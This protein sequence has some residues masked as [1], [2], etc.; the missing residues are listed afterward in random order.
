MITIPIVKEHIQ[1]KKQTIIKE[2]KEE[3]TFIKE[4]I[5][6]IKLINTN[7]IQ[8]VKC[9]ENIISAFTNLL[10]CIWIKNSKIVNI[11]KHSKSWWN[12]N[13]SRN[14]EKYRLSKS[15]KDWKQYKKTFRVTK[16]N[17]FN[18]KIQEIFNKKKGS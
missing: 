13:C 18:L 15:I 6:V 10:E 17:F 3:H 12:N 1:T 4:L 11:T 14:L 2:S 7:V 8:D 5:E 9:L 16:H